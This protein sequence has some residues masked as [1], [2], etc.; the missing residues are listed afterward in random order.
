MASTTAKWQQRWETSEKRQQTKSFLPVV[1]LVVSID[2]MYMTF[3]VIGHVTF[4][5]KLFDGFKRD[6]SMQVRRRADSE[7]NLEE[8]P[9]NGTYSLIHEPQRRPEQKARNYVIRKRQTSIGGIFKTLDRRSK[10]R[11]AFTRLGLVTE[12]RVSEVK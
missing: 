6:G 1:E 2:N 10:K 4:N 12:L 5:A 8:M 9:V 7:P 11:F 3:F